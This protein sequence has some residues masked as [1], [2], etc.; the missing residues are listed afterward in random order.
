[1]AS[2]PVIINIVLGTGSALKIQAIKNA[3]ASAKEKLAVELV[4]GSPI[5]FK[6]FT[7]NAK[8][9][10]NEQPIGW[11]ETIKG[12][13]NRASNALTL[14]KSDLKPRAVVAIENGVVDLP[15]NGEHYY[16]DIGWVVL[17][18]LKTNKQYVSSSTSLSVPAEVVEAAKEKSFKTTTIGDIL[19]ERDASISTKD[20]HSTLLG[21]VMTRIPLMQQAVLSCLGQWI[22]ALQSSKKVV[23][24][25]ADHKS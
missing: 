12:A 25:M 8:S 19:H 9:G 10:I 21:G 1:M 5:K 7:T 16:M 4:D 6:F 22:F 3:F 15:A 18:D 17:N 23:D 24:Q 2:D 11:E 13:N 14:V 20:P